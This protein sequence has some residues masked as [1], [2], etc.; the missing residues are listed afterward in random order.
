[1][2][3][4]IANK[5]IPTFQWYKFRTIIYL[6]LK[7]E[8]KHLIILNFYFVLTMNLEFIQTVIGPAV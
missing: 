4:H 5:H 7:G 2:Q 6:N 1:M 8:G 3:T